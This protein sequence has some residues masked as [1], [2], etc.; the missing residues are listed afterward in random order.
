MNKKTFSGGITF[1]LVV[2]LSIVTS[3]CSSNMDEPTFNAEMQNSSASNSISTTNPQLRGAINHEIGSINP[4]ALEYVDNSKTLLYATGALDNRSAKLSLLTNISSYERFDESEETSKINPMALRLQLL[5]IVDDETGSAVNFYD[6]PQDQR[7]IFVDELL[8]EDA[9]NISS[10]LDLVPEASQMLEIENRATTKLITE[11]EIPIMHVGDI[12][13]VR[14]K[15]VDRLSTQPAS[16]STKKNQTR[17]KTIDHKAFFSD[18][19]EEIESEMNNQDSRNSNLLRSIGSSYNYPKID[20]E[21]VVKPAWIRAARRGDFIL[22]IPNHFHPWIFLNI[23]KNVKFKVGHAGIINSKI[24]PHTSI[25]D[26]V[27]IESWSDNGVQRLSMDVWDTPHY[28][29]G[30]QKVKYKWRWRGFKS[31]IYKVKTPVSNP[32]ALADWANKY[33]GRGYVRWYEFVT[34]KW[35]APSRF[36]CTTLVWWC[37]KKAYGINVS[38][39]YSP[40]VT[41]SGLLTDDETYVRYNIH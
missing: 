3:G 39:W 31:G 2:S 12:S 41:P 25:S 40:L 1:A 24:T 22:A 6:L 16:Q 28:I 32:D 30:V 18:L 33:V 17:T 38:S 7:E 34:A 5:D 20:V 15:N 29:M 27:T 4:L 35:A 14:L 37:A 23:G 26:N 9:R 11:N 19:R 10:K 13:N 36:T 8:Q 21:K